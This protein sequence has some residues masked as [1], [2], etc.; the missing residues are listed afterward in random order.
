MRP[1]SYR[2]VGRHEVAG[3]WVPGVDV[4]TQ[5]Q[6]L[7][8]WRP[9]ST[10]CTAGEGLWLRWPVPVELRVEAVPGLPVVETRAG[11]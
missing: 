8:W 1:A 4:A 5:R 2:Y 11:R 6:L 3:L 7:A 10:V 9:G